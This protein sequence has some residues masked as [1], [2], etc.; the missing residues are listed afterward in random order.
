MFF[1]FLGGGPSQQHPHHGYKTIHTRHERIETTS[2]TEEHL[3]NKDM[4]MDDLL[5]N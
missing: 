3:V 1:I 2:T 4:D 5:K